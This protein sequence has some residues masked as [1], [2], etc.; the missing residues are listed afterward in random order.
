MIDSCVEG[1]GDG[2]ASL[3]GDSLSIGSRCADIAPQVVGGQIYV[4]ASVYNNP[5]QRVLECRTGNRR[6]I[7]GVLSDV[8]EHRV[9]RRPNCQLLED[10]MGGCAMHQGHCGRN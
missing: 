6:V 3:D 9:L 8:L 2:V 4:V 10:V 1:E 5:R 7:V